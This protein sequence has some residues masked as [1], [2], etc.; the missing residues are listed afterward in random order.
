MRSLGRGRRGVISEI[1]RKTVGI[2]KLAY[3]FNQTEGGKGH[4][5]SGLMTVQANTFSAPSQTCA[6]P[7]ELSLRLPR[8]SV[9]LPL[10][11]FI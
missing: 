6:V 5:S 3:D 11:F 7:Q 9:I 8:P 10:G 4:R 2:E 1:I